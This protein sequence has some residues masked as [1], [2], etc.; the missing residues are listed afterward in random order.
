VLENLVNEK[1]ADG[2]I[3]LPKGATLSHQL[4]LV[5]RGNIISKRDGKKVAEKF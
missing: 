3:V 5:L 1:K 2:E 4:I